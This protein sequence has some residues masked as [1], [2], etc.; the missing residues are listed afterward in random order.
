VHIGRRYFC[1]KCGG[2]RPPA[3]CREV[4]EER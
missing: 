3:G 2:L 1:L 4:E